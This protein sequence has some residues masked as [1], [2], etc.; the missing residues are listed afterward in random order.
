MKII[1]LDTETTAL[2]MGS[3]A[4]AHKQP[5]IVEIGAI[6][7]T[8]HGEAEVSQLINPG[9]HISEDATKITGIKDEDVVHKP[10]L[11]VY[12]PAMAVWYSGADLVVGHNVGFDLDVLR[13][14]LRRLGF[15]KA[16]WREPKDVICT[17]AEYQ[18]V[19]GFKPRMIDM[20]PRIMGEELKQTHRALDDCKALYNCLKK[21]RFFQKIGV[22]I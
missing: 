10:T 5:R 6:V 22:H 7:I 1:I 3:I 21:D 18:H 9:C 12:L 4:E 13:Y 8:R 20:Y 15:E 19:F 16:P 2:T 14:E 17:A 11:D